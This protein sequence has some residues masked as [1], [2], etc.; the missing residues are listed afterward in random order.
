MADTFTW[1]P[2]FGGQVD[3]A[4]RLLESAFGDGYGQSGA[5]GINNMPLVRTLTF[6][7]RDSAE[8]AAIDA[9]LRSQGGAKWFW[10]T[11]PGKTAI[12]VKCKKWSAVPIAA[13]LETLSC[14]FEQVFN[15]GA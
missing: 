9:F 4:P 11:Y 8:I 5:D 10:F 13:N 15:P 6:A 12:K 7:N 2:D 14:I 3:T 1:V